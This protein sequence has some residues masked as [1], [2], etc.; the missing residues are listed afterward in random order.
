MAYGGG[1]MPGGIMK[2][3]GSFGAVP[4]LGVD[5]DA[6]GGGL[7]FWES[8]KWQLFGGWSSVAVPCDLSENQ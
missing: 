4:A 5:A 1:C 2:G 3:I 6:C 8:E 7:S